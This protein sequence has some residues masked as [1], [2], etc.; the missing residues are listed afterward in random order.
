MNRKAHWDRVYATKRPT[1]LSWY[2]AEPARSL[3][4]LRQA[5]A[6]P[7]TALIDI[8]GGDSTLVDA[9]VAQHLGRV[10]V[11]DISAAGLARARHRLGARADE[12]TW[13]E[14]DVTRVE[15]PAQAFDV[16]HD[17]AAF[18]FLTQAGD[19]SRYVANAATALRA[20][21][22]LLIATFAPTGPRAAAGSTSCATAPRAW[23]GRSERRSCSSRALP[24]CTARPA[25][26]SSAS[27][28]PSCGAVDSSRTCVDLG[29]TPVAA[30]P[31][32]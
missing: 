2:Q 23:P 8:G 7:G 13:I 6:G 27:P 18:H 9:V 28:T 17:R 29:S 3:A 32:D 22:T 19:R 16:W 26:P 11:L 31:C 20:G 15:L 10:T 12:V 25:E 1:E 30:S 14:A 21:G 5:Q 24:T 4:L